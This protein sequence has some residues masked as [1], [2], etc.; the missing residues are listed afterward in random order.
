L[1]AVT[2]HAYTLAGISLGC[3][4]RFVQAV[5]PFVLRW[6]IP[7]DGFPETAITRTPVVS[8]DFFG[9]RIPANHNLPRLNQQ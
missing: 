8:Q 4:L 1:I 2:P 9:S 3:V 5:C 6:P 7:V